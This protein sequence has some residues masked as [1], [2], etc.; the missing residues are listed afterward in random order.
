MIPPALHSLG[1]G[2]RILKN[3][4]QK[5]RGHSSSTANSAAVFD[6]LSSTLAC[7][8]GANLQDPR[9]DLCLCCVAGFSSSDMTLNNI[10]CMI[11]LQC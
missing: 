4:H 6:S 9:T 3:A 1:W 11:G 10:Y 8:S 2:S 7:H 5:V